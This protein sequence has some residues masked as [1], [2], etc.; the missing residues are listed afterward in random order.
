[1]FNGFKPEINPE[2]IKVMKELND[3]LMRSGH[4]FIFLYGPSLPFDH[5]YLDNLNDTL[6]KVGIRHVM[7]DPFIMKEDSKG[8]TN[9]HVHPDFRDSVT[10]YYQN[11]IE[12]AAF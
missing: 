1:M 4:K 11:M 12:K 6:K 8:D 3:K 5:K 10:R 7:N 9:A 2:K